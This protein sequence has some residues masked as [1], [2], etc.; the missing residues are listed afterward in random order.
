MCCRFAILP[1]NPQCYCI[2]L[3]VLRGIYALLTRTLDYNGVFA[4]TIPISEWNMLNDH[5]KIPY[6]MRTLREQSADIELLGD[7][8]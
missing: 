3:V 8:N 1:M 6:I 2:N 4:V 5:E 7:L